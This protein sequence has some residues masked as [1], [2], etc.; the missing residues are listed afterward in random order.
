LL[1]V[2]G[3]LHRNIGPP[4]WYIK[5]LF[6]GEKPPKLGWEVRSREPKDLKDCKDNKDETGQTT[7]MSLQSLLSFGSFGPSSN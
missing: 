7:S 4:D 2:S 5:P 6:Q 3:S 1:R